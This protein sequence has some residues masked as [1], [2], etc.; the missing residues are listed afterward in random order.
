MKKAKYGSRVP[1]TYARGAISAEK[2][3][4]LRAQRLTYSEIGR[5]MGISGES[6]RMTVI[7]E[8]ERLRASNAE[9]AEE[10]RAQELESLDEL[11]ARL[12]EQALAGDVEDPHTLQCV[13]RV[14]KIKERRAR[15][16]G[17][18]AKG[19][20]EI[21]AASADMA[22]KIYIPDDGSGPDA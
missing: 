1:N 7:R 21:A 15:L 12:I 2:A 9:T 3:L 8:Y 17:L 19:G 14:L 4:Q 13:D 5:R 10:V 11:E 6:A 20:I 18:D 22:V 16:L